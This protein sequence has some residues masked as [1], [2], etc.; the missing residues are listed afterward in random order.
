MTKDLVFIDIE[1]TDKDEKTATV[2]EIGAIRCTPRGVVLEQY[3]TKVR[4]ESTCT[5]EAARINGYNERDW[6]DATDF[7]VALSQLH[8]RMIESYPLSA[9]VVSYFFFDHNVMLRQFRDKHLTNFP[10]DGHPWLNFADMAYPLVVT[11]RIDSRKLIDLANYLEVPP[12]KGHR[13]LGDATALSQCYFAYCK[14]FDRSFLA[15]SIG[16]EVV[17]GIGELFKPKVLPK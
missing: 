7:A 12:W 11:G 5:P 4:P 6:T 9:V 2:L 15:G 17:R 1:A 3:E 10:F 8:F 16:R 14:R 13:A